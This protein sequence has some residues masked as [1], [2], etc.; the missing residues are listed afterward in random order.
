MRDT[1]RHSETPNRGGCVS[2]WSHAA[3]NFAVGEAVRTRALQTRL[4]PRVPRARLHWPLQLQ[5]QLQPQLVCADSP[6][7]HDGLTPPCSRASSLSSSRARAQTQRASSPRAVPRPSPFSPFLRPL[8]L[9]P[10]PISRRLPVLLRVTPPCSR[11][12]S[13]LLVLAP[14]HSHRHGLGLKRSAQ[15]VHAP[16]LL[17]LA[18]PRAC[19]CSCLLVL[20]PL[21]S[22]RS[23]APSC[24]HLHQF[25]I[26]SPFSL[27]RA[28]AQTPRK[29]GFPSPPSRVR[30][31][32]QMHM[33]SPHASSSRARAQTPRASPLDTPEASHSASTSPASSVSV[34]DAPP[35]LSE[36]P[37]SGRVP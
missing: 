14:P 23:C 10:S 34:V 22:P 25:H 30:T 27:S 9:A 37:R 15:V 3:E 7:M 5:L 31:V 24:S 28:R 33:A 12:E 18:S 19:S 36:S 26:V 29:R 1:V 20:V 6:S 11:S 8:V 4:S 21:L 16:S 32:R 13:R 2:T 17:I 35:F